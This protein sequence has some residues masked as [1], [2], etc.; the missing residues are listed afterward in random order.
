L[1]LDNKTISNDV[2]HLE[3]AASR[4]AGFDFEAGRIKN[5]KNSIKANARG[6]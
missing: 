3:S 1:I 5:N 2:P 4:Q 6:F